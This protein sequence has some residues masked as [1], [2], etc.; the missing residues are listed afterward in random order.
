[1]KT[2]S[3]ALTIRLGVA[4]ASAAVFAYGLA[5]DLYEPGAEWIMPV[6]VVA[7]GASVARGWV[8]LSAVVPVLIA[9]PEGTGGD[10]PAVPA[11]FIGGLLG[12]GLLALGVQIGKALSSGSADQ[13]VG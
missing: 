11:A 2:P 9:L 13:E 12:A 8:L 1:M 10:P 3:D 4:T 7:F 6:A 5:T